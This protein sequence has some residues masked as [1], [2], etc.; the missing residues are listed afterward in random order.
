MQ[1]RLLGFAGVA[2]YQGLFEWQLP[3]CGLMPV[4]QGNLGAVKDAGRFPNFDRAPVEFYVANGWA[5][6]Q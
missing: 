1:M 2:V 5:Q 6:E 4:Q 3:W